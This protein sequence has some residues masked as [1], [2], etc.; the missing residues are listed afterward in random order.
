[1]DI[2]LKMTDIPMDLR[3]KKIKFVDGKM[4]DTMAFLADKMAM[5]IFL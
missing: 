3:P 1:M 2:D 4:R 5:I